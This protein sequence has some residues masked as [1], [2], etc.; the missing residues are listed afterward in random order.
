MEGVVLYVVLVKVFVSQ[1]NKR[2]YMIAFAVIS[3]GTPDVHCMSLYCIFDT[4]SVNLEIIIFF[5][6]YLSFIWW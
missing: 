6:A 5:Q 1:S 2:A 3:Y 4:V